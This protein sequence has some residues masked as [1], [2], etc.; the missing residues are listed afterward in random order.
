MVGQWTL[1]LKQYSPT[2]LSNSVSNL[3]FLIQE[4]HVQFIVTIVV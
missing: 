4:A 1:T 3:K 2:L